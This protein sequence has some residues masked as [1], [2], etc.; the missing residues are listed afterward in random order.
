MTDEERDLY[1]R[2][3]QALR[4]CVFVIDGASIWQTLKAAKELLMAHDGLAYCQVCG[5]LGKDRDFET[6][7]WERC[8]MCAGTG[9]VKRDSEA[10]IGGEA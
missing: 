2:T 4:Q 6:G 7:K 8:S 10:A 9:T 3:V 5:G 1:E